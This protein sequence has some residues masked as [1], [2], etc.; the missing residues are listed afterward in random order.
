[1]NDDWEA[2]FI[3]R[4][5]LTR[6]PVAKQAVLLPPATSQNSPSGLHHGVLAL[7]IDESGVVNHVKPL[8]P[9][10]PPALEK[11]AMDAFMRA[12]FTPGQLDGKI[13]KSRI[14]VEIEFERAPLIKTVPMQ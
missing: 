5:Q 2:Q 8:P 11:I 13:V 12:R 10:L 7:Y 4:P 14:K 1:M 9:K 3:P 6:P